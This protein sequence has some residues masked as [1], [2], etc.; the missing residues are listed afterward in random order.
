MLTS[1][2]LNAFCCNK[3]NEELDNFTF[4]AAS[5]EE[6]KHIAQTIILAFKQLGIF[7]DHGYLMRDTTEPMCAWFQIEEETFS[8]WVLQTNLL[9][10]TN[11]VPIK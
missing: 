3:T 11:V 10:P 2:T 4:L 7:L 6:A 8:P 1:Y 5:N 9:V